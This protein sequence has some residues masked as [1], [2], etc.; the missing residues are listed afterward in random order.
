MNKKGFTLIELLIVVAIIGI[1]AAVGAVVIPNVLGNT[2]KSASQTN[3]QT[4]VDFI[5]ISVAQCSI[6]QELILKYSYD[7][8]T[9]KTT[10]TS[11]QCSIVLAGNSSK[12]QSAFANHFNSPAWC[13][14]YGLKHSSGTCQ[15]A[16]AN[17]GSVNNG[18][19]GETLITNS[20]S[21]FLIINTK[22]SN[23]EFLTNRINLVN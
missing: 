10:Y 1:L 20:N 2:K 7:L 23:S 6:G 9:K 21:N 5:T 18:S 3:H 22:I 11:D 19:L 8:N 13:N 17:G 15:E 12:M 4:V 16:I 14:P